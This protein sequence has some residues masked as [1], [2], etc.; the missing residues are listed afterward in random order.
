MIGRD[1]SILYYA[2]KI[3]EL[4]TKKMFRSDKVLCGNYRT[5]VCTNSYQSLS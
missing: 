4:H 5:F 3:K 2:S 1:T